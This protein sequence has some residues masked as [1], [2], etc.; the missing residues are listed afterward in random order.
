MAGSVGWAVASG[1]GYVYVAVQ[2]AARFA[3]LPE[4][5]PA[6]PWRLVDQSLQTQ[7]YFASPIV[8][9]LAGLVVM[10]QTDAIRNDTRKTRYF[11]GGT[12]GLRGYAIGDL[13][14]TTQVIAH[15]ELRS[16]PLPVFSQRFGGIVFYDVGDA[17]S[18]FEVLVP[19]H[20]VGAGLRW[21]IPQLNSAVLRFDW[22]VAAEGTR[23]T[24][25]GLPG[26]FSAGFMQVF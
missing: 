13:E 18:S 14:G 8:G 9:H 3:H 15:V 20:D 4:A 1:G 16:L 22:A 2:G 10:A 19:H 23:Y 26:R 6:S 24:R 5:G 21:L 17:A 12:T 7:A 11:L 25:A